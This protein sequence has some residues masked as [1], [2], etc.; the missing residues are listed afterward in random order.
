LY[1]SNNNLSLFSNDNLLKNLSWQLC[2]KYDFF[3][4]FLHLFSWFI[5]W[6]SLF[7]YVEHPVHLEIFHLITSCILVLQYFDKYINCQSLSYLISVLFSKFNY[8]ILIFSAL[9]TSISFGASFVLFF[10]FRFFY[11]LSRSIYYYYLIHNKTYNYYFS[12]FYQDE[13]FAKNKI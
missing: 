7:N 3:L 2:L 4:W 12:N 13:H 6:F 9:R 1:L 10:K 11:I 5:I 8:L